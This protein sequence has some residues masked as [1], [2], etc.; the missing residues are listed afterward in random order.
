MDNRIVAENRQIG[1]YGILKENL[2]IA[3]DRNINKIEIVST[4]LSLGIGCGVTAVAQKALFDR[5][6]STTE[7][8]Y[9]CGVILFIDLP[10]HILNDT[11]KLILNAKEEMFIDT[12]DLL[13]YDKLKSIPENYNINDLEPNACCPISGIELK[14]NDTVLCEKQLYSYEALKKWHTY[15]N[16]TSKMVPHTGNIPLKW[17]ENVYKLPRYP[18]LDE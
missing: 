9:C 4:L 6:V 16:N 12:P 11:I 17:D 10:L 8:L 2:K 18:H 13:P 1:N 15:K 14:E 3:F 5:D 7:L